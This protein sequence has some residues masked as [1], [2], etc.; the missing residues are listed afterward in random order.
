MI[1]LVLAAATAMT[2]AQI[3]L[4][5]AAHVDGMCEYIG[6]WGGLEEF[7]IPW[8]NPTN[9]AAVA[10]AVKSEFLKGRDD[11]ARLGL[12]NVRCRL[13]RKD[14]VDRVREAAKQP[15]PAPN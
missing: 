3:E 2:P 9:D 6:H 4:I 10:E 12:D 13:L 5:K 8:A 15:A 14:A 1:A 7:L 11:P